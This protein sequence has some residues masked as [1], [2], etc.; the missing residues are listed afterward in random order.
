MFDS[1]SQRELFDGLVLWSDIH[2]ISLGTGAS[3]VGKSITVRR[4]VQSRD[5][6]RIR[7]F[8]FSYLP[9]TVAGFLRLL[10]RTLGLSMRHHVADLFDQAQKFL[11]SFQKEQGP[12]PLLLIDDAEGLSMP[13]LDV[14][15]RLTCYELD[16]EDRFS[17]LLVGTEEMLTTLR[18]PSLAPLCSRIR[19]AHALRPFTFEDTRNY[20]THHLTR[21]EVD[22]K[23]FS[24]EAVRHLFQGSMGRPRLINQLA[25]Q[26]LIRAAVIGREHIDGEFMAKEIAAHP[27][28]HVA[29][30][31]Q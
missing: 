28:Y 6:S 26:A 11:A 31:S 8:A 3:G 16:A 2:G 15:R 19:Y 24:D 23:L 14:L 10:N 20:V 9:T 22:P 29:S 18:H 17:L 1:S 4:F 30:S 13:V 27:L 12:H 21:A 5:E 7:V 25:L